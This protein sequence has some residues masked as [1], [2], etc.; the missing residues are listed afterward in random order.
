MNTKQLLK[1]LEDRS[2][3]LLAWAVMWRM[4]VLVLGFYAAIFLIALIFIGL[5]EL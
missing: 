5:A 1:K 3:F 4:W 2:P